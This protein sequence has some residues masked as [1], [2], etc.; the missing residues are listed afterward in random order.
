VK[1]INILHFFAAIAA[2]NIIENGKRL[3]C[4]ISHIFIPTYISLLI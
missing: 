3:V 1:D 4:D 2:K